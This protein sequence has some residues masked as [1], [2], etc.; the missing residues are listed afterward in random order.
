MKERVEL[1]IDENGIAVATI[2]HAPLNIYDLEKLEFKPIND[3]TVQ[4]HQNQNNIKSTSYIN[5]FFCIPK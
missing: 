5:N 4:K 2:S 1:S 3:F